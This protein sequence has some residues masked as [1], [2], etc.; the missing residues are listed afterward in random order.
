MSILTA[1]RMIAIHKASGV[2]VSVNAR[3]VLPL[4]T[5]NKEKTIETEG[6]RTPDV[7]IAMNLKCQNYF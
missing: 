1:C 7:K 3:I 6:V 4:Q 5:R 2:E